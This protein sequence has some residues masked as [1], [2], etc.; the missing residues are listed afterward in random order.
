MW[1]RIVEFW[2]RWWPGWAFV[3]IGLGILLLLA[4]AYATGGTGL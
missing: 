3:F 4:A 1:W 2:E